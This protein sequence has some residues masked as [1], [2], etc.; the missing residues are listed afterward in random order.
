MRRHK[1][2]RLPP[3]CGELRDAIGANSINPDKSQGFPLI[4]VVGSPGDDFRVDRVCAR[5]ELLVDE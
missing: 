1:I 4:G 3:V 2:A 5:D